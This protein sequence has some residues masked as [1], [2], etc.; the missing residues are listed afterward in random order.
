MKQLQTI[1]KGMHIFE[2]LT[3]IFMVIA[4]VWAIPMP[5]G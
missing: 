2:V 1:Q 3:K 4:I 5:F